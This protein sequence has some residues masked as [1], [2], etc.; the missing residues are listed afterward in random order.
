MILHVL[1]YDYMEY[2]NYVLDQGKHR[3]FFF[4]RYF[5]Y[6]ICTTAV[7]PNMINTSFT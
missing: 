5:L 6:K 1:P 7:T 2:F 4:L 3:A